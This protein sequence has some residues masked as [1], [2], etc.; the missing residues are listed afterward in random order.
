MCSYTF[1]GS[2][3]DGISVVVAG[4][5]RSSVAETLEM[6]RGVQ[7]AKAPALPIANSCG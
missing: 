5:A 3:A 7:I 2:V 1:L 4:N 6:A